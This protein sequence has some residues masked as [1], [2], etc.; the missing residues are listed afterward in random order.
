MQL[1]D[2]NE[3]NFFKSYIC[4]SRGNCESCR[5]KRAFREWVYSRHDDVAKV[6]FEC[7]HGIKSEDFDK[8]KKPLKKPSLIKMAKNFGS[9]MAKSLIETIRTQ[10]LPLV[11]D[12]LQRT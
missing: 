12:D 7:P 2:E 8:E 9:S 6:E 3:N 1:D 4:E 10:E 11:N 5:T